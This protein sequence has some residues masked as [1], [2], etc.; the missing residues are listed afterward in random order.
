[1]TNNSLKTLV[2]EIIENRIIGNKKI[3]EYVKNSKKVKTNSDKIIFLKEYARKSPYP[4]LYIQDEFLT[5]SST[6]KEYSQFIIWLIKKNSY[7][8]DASSFTGI[9]EKNP[10]LGKFLFEELSKSKEI[11]VAYASGTILGGLGIKEP[12]KLYDLLSK[13]SFPNHPEIILMN[14]ILQTSYYHKIPKKNILEILDYTKSKDDEIKNHAIS[15]LMDRFNKNSLI[16]KKILQF[17]KSNDKMKQFISQRT[18]FMHRDNKKLSIKILQE[19]IKTKD[20]KIKK[21]I[22]SNLSLISEEYPMYILS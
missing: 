9:Y 11:S 12:E 21:D 16:Q 10:K 2:K 13:N 8:L 14:S 20:E 17:A 3:I 6:T 22:I 7:M 4:G 18:T 15:I 19:C 1:M 5:C